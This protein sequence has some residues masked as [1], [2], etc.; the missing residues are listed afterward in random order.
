MVMSRKLR[1]SFRVIFVIF[2][3]SV[4]Y[5]ALDPAP[6]VAGTD[7]DKV[8]HILAFFT[9]G[10]LLR[11]G[12]PRYRLVLCMLGLLLVGGLIEIVQHFVG[13]DAA[14]GDLAADAIGLL[15]AI[16]ATSIFRMQPVATISE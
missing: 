5:L 11:M 2:F 7:S 16:A 3:V 9:L 6:F 14:W 12:W 15:L 4:L 8:N 10:V 1:V 13:R